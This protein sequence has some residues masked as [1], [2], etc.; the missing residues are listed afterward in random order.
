MYEYETVWATADERVRITPDESADSPREDDNLGVLATTG[1]TTAADTDQLARMAAR[2]LAD[3]GFDA[4][5]EVLRDGHGSAAVVPLREHF[6]NYGATLVEC[7]PGDAT[8]VVFDTAEVRGNFGTPVELVRG[9]LLAEVGAY[10]E[11]LTGDV[12]V[13]LHERRAVWCRRDDPAVTRDE[14]EVVESVGGYFGRDYAVASAN[15]EF[16][17]PVAP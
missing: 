13:I 6:D 5:A 14:W 7:A 10:N 15:E 3:E 1:R 11:Y 8:G 17:Y 4:L 12:W 16:P 9:C 2:V